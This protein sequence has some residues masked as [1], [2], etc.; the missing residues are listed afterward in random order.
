MKDT[1]SVFK[2]PRLK[3]QSGRNPFDLS[4]KTVFTAPFGT[5]VP[6]GFWRVSANDY[7]EISNESQFICPQ[8]NRPA[9]MRLKEHIDYF[10]VG[11]SQVWTPGDNFITAQDYYFSTA[12]QQIC[13]PDSPLSPTVPSVVPMFDAT[14]LKKLFEYADTQADLWQF[15]QLGNTLRLLDQLNYGY[16]F[17]IDNLDDPGSSASDV[18]ID[19]VPNMN[20]FALACY[21]KA[22]YDY[23]RNSMYEQ[24]RVEAY[25]L[26]DITTKHWVQTDQDFT[27][28]EDRFFRVFELHYRWL[29]KDYF[30]STQTAVLPN[31][32]MLGF[33]GF[34]SNIPLNSPSIQ[35]PNEVNTFSPGP[36]VQNPG[37]Q[38][39]N[40]VVT[41]SNEYQGTYSN[42]LSV[43]APISSA[44]VS[45]SAIRFA[46]AYDK[47]LRRMREAGQDFDKQMLAQF[48]IA[49]I[50][51]RHGK[52]YRIGGFVNRLSPQSVNNTASD[53]GNIGGN[54]DTYSM[55]N[56]P[57][58]FHCKEPGFIIAVYST[59][60]DTDYCLPRIARDNVAQSRFDW[61]HKDFENLGLQ[62]IFRF[63]Y[64]M[65]VQPVL[66]I[67]KQRQ[68]IG[69]NRRYSEYKTHPDEVHG[70]ISMA[71]DS[72]YDLQ[73][74]SAQFAEIIPADKPLTMKQLVHNPNQLNNILPVN[75]DG[76]INKDPFIINMYH[77]FHKISNMSVYGEDFH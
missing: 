13:N 6:C 3:S 2:R 29:K 74:W 42:D 50:D 17:D 53:L 23:Y 27:N 19:G 8:L 59:S 4:Y 31:T 20:F 68:V 10:Y 66:P 40:G 51:Q 22:Y 32:Q 43:N 62:P 44:Q 26:D 5:L 49:P 36:Y 61:F 46:F 33:N 28:D 71:S 64:D 7:V 70:R 58:K 69:L 63:E 16:Y 14:F 57:L 24:N 45:V 35:P 52:C 65:R 56:R 76:T 9:F 37:A 73:A 34:V 72:S 48:G 55:N 60:I 77:R 39:G 38:L 1:K 75:Y 21:Q 18:G 12:I 15:S 67:A 11:L 41:G 54:I 30:T 47:L 25:N